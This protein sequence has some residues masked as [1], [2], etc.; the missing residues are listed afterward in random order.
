VE[1]DLIE[2]WDKLE[3]M[4]RVDAMEEYTLIAYAIHNEA[5]FDMLIENWSATSYCE[6]SSQ[7][8]KDPVAKVV[9]N[10][11][12]ACYG[13]S[14]KITPQRI[15]KWIETKKQGTPEIDFS[16]FSECL[17]KVKF[18][19]EDF[20]EVL[21]RI[22]LRNEKI[23]FMNELKG[24]IEIS[25]VRE[26]N[27]YDAQTSF[28]Y[29]LT[30]NHSMPDFK[31][32]TIDNL[33]QKQLLIGKDT[34]INPN[35]TLK[36]CLSTWDLKLRI[37]WPTT[38]NIESLALYTIYEEL[39]NRD[40]ESNLIF[41]SNENML[42]IQDIAYH[43]S[44][45]EMK[46][47]EKEY[48]MHRQ[49]LHAVIDKITSLFIFEMKVLNFKWTHHLSTIFIYDLDLFQLTIPKENKLQYLIK[50]LCDIRI[51]FKINI[52][53]LQTNNSYENTTLRE[54]ISTIR[55]PEFESIQLVFNEH[56]DIVVESIH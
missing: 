17:C 8:F 55:N 4:T 53:I 18:D 3:L 45:K 54:E 56:S 35:S 26:F 48:V 33:I 6:S 50:K 44:M 29:S 31:V 49:C 14:I 24:L 43:L 9:L 1:K 37:V 11:L 22:A 51:D 20:K 36:T 13:N 52:I 5:Y 47:N 32:E 42:R 38:K 40:N 28:Y 46:Q 39:Y 16:S 27:L 30:S 25:S 41:A 21:K 7:L 10:Q 12:L 34:E 19:E 15:F 23:F 2:K